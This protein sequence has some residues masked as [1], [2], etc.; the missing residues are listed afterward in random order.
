M[1]EQDPNREARKQVLDVTVEFLEK[2][3]SE[4]HEFLSGKKELTLKIDLDIEAVVADIAMLNSLKHFLLEGETRKLVVR[5][6]QE[7]ADHFKG[8]FP[9]GTEWQIIN[10]E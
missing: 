9:L 5:A 3:N 4:F 7:E 2:T 6:S 10:R 8:Q 1:P